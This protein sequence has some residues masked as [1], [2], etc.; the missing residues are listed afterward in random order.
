MQ[1][2]MIIRQLDRTFNGPAWHGPS[3]IETLDK[4][5]AAHAQ[6][7]F[8]DS[9]TV[10][11][12]IAHMAT[13]KKFVAEHVKGNAGYDVS[14]A[15]NFP[16]ATNLTE[17]IQRLKDSQ[18]DLLAALKQFPEGKMKDKVPTREYSFQTMLHGIIHHDLYH[19]G[20]ITLLNR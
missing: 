16:S 9:H 4:I 8:K 18:E 19:L 5:T 14:E 17:T 6:N 20:Q 15:M 12:L 11:Q 7:Q 3:V 1:L 13:W 10:I 2:N